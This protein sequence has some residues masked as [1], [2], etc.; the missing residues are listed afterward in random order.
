MQEAIYGPEYKNMKMDFTK[1]TNKNHVPDMSNE[2][3]AHQEVPLAQAPLHAADPVMDPALKTAV[4]I[5]RD[6]AEVAK[7]NYA[8]KAGHCFGTLG[9]IDQDK[10]AQ[11]SYPSHIARHLKDHYG[12]DK[13]YYD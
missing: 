1:A 8:L 12:M 10:Y 3:T 2:P 9:T 11:V 7:S 13:K 5:L 6:I 4:I